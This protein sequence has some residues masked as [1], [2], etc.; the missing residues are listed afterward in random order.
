MELST[1]QL[2]VIAAVGVLT[3]YWILNYGHLKQ[4]KGNETAYTLLAKD[5]KSM[6]NTHYNN[7]QVICMTSEDGKSLIT[8]GKIV[9]R[10]V[11]QI[12]YKVYILKQVK[13]TPAQLEEKK[14]VVIEKDG[15]T[16]KRLNMTVSGDLMLIEFTDYSIGFYEQIINTTKRLIGQNRKYVIYETYT[17]GVKNFKDDSYFFMLPCFLECTV[18]KNLEF[19]H[20]KE[21]VNHLDLIINNLKQEYDGYAGIGEAIELG[22]KANQ[23]FVNAV[24]YE[25]HKTQSSS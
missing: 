7:N 20:L 18:I 11:R 16:F 21:P 19:Y 6:S 13:L 14:E 23:K 12:D 8:L 5:L 3:L 4:I 22:Q 1:P 9:S 17:N 15:K 10:F 24:E 2:I 25:V